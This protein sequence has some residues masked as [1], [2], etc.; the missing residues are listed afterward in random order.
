[1]HKS[2]ECFTDGIVSTRKLLQYFCRE[3]APEQFAFMAPMISQMVVNSL[4]KVYVTYCQKLATTP[5][6]EGLYYVEC[7]EYVDEVEYVG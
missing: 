7:V 6:I 2:N 5:N 4:D 1:M 3:C